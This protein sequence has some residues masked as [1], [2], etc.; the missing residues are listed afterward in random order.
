MSD[1]TPCNYDSLQQMKKRAAS[2]TD[3]WGNSLGISVVL[4]R[5][6]PEADGWVSAR[7][8]DQEKP[9]AYFLVLPNRC[10]C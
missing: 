10:V 3:M 6:D 9:S 7:Y 2:R 1:L 4:T 5:N 8:S